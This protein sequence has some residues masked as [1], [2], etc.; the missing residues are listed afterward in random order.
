MEKLNYSLKELKD[1]CNKKDYPSFWLDHTTRPLARFVIKLIMNT[2]ITPNQITLVALLLGLFASLAFAIGSYPLIIL[3]GLSLF[4]SKVFDCTDGQLARLKKNGSKFG[5]W[6]DGVVDV[7]LFSIT[8]MAISIGLSRVTGNIIFL[9]IG[10]WTSIAV[11]NFIFSSTTANKLE[12]NNVANLSVKKSTPLSWDDGLEYLL[13]M[14]SAFFN[15]LGI[16]LFI[17]FVKNTIWLL[18][19]NL[20]IIKRYYPRNHL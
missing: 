7:F 15:A 8:P 13:I 9:F 19:K 14:I 4:I 16:M 3:G 18:A 1:I 6:L 2:S 20:L 17:L 12:E 10:I 11:S 5:G